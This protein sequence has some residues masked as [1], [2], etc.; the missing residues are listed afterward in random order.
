MVFDTNL[1]FSETKLHVWSLARLDWT[2]SSDLV[3]GQDSLDF[4]IEWFIILPNLLKGDKEVFTLTVN[5][6]L[7]CVK[8]SLTVCS[9]RNLEYSSFLPYFSA[10]LRTNGEGYTP[11]EVT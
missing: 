4:L 7:S 6:R 11:D 5:C 3:F 9:I 1:L 10:N 2:A 8:K